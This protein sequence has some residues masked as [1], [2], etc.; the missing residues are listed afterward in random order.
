[1]ANGAGARGVVQLYR[2][3][4]DGYTVG[5]I[6]IPGVFILQQQQNSRDY[7]L[8]DVSWF[9]AIGEGEHYVLAVAA[10]SPIRSLDDL[11]ALSQ[12]RPVRFS[13]TGPAGTGQAATVIGTELLGVR[14]QLISGYS[15]S[16]EFIV[17]A[18]RGDSDAVV[19][20]LPTALRYMQAGHIRFL[21]SF[22]RTSSIP[23]IPDATSLGQPDLAQITVERVVG[24]P[25][26]LPGEI[27]DVLSDALANA[28]TDPAVV[29]W[30]AQ[31][32]LVMTPKTPAQVAAIVARQREFFDRWKN[33][34]AAG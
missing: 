17:A 23:D 7:D 34:L 10:D 6:N 18:I 33:Y 25:P 2:A 19:A 9:G 11:K 8:A 22:E 20:S 1:M 29:R 30:G 3:R 31:N 28:L 12:R 5:I 21:A 14:R 27:R 26:G 13:V 16:A 24:A 15:G 4:P 32:N